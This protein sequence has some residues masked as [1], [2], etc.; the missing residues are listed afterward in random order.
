[1]SSG[2]GGVEEVEAKR[3]QLRASKGMAKCL[4]RQQ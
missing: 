2:K 3:K 4:C 1:M